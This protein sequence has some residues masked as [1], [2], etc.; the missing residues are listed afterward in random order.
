MGKSPLI[1]KPPF[2]DFLNTF[3]RHRTSKS[4]LWSTYYLVQVDDPIPSFHVLLKVPAQEMAKGSMGLTINATALFSVQKALLWKWFH[5]LLNSHKK[6][7]LFF[8]AW[9]SGVTYWLWLVYFY[10]LLSMT[11]LLERFPTNQGGWSGS[12][13][14]WF[15]RIRIC[16]SLTSLGDLVIPL[17]QCLPWA[18]GAKP[19]GDLDYIS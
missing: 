12:F 5:P 4:K 6:N 18:T 19:R 9:F 2:G 10:V 16:T 17:K 15:L 8:F 13:S 3:S 11:K 14:A 7:T 1:I